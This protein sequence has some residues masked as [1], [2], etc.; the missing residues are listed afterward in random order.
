L[1]EKTFHLLVL[2]VV[3]FLFSKS[4]IRIIEQF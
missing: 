3:V 4:A 1:P 2:I